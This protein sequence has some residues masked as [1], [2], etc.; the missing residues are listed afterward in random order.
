MSRSP[1][2]FEAGY[3]MGINAD[4]SLSAFDISTYVLE[5][6][7]GYVIGYSFSE[8]V[9][10]ASPR[11]C[12]VIAADLGREYRIPYDHLIKYFKDSDDLAVLQHSDD[13]AR[14]M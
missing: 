1:N 4:S 8:S 14:D 11:A 7:I 5:F 13:A 9:R 3:N 2:P 12:A 10:Q 6:Q